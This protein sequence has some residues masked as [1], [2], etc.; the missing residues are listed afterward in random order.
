MQVY[1]LSYNE[2]QNLEVGL[3]DVFVASYFFFSH[4]SLFLL[5]VL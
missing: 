4:F 1:P 5:L 2:N 3:S